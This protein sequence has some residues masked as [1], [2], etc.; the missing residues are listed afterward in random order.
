MPSITLRSRRKIS[1]RQVMGRILKDDSQ[2]NQRLAPFFYS[3]EFS[4]FYKLT[5]M[6]KLIANLIF[7]QSILKLFTGDRQNDTGAHS[8][9]WKIANFG[10]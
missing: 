4:K 6:Q 5:F 8:Q 7:A 1:W 10:L 9:I 2:K 3:Q